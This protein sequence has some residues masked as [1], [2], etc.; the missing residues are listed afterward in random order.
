M[1]WHFS[2]ALVE[3][4]LGENSLDGEPSA[5]SSGT[6]THGMCWSLDKTTDA[7]TRSRSGMM[8]KPLTDT[9]GEAVLMS[10]LEAFPARTSVPQEK[11]RGSTESGAVCGATWQESS[12]KFDPD[13]SSWK[14]HLCLWEEDLPES[15]VTLPKWGMMRDGVCWE[16]TTLAL[17]IRGTESGSWPSPRTSGIC[18]GSGSREMIQAKVLD[19][20]LSEE[21]AVM[22]LGVK[23]WPTPAARDGKG[24]N[25]REHCET[26]GTGRKHMDQLP[27]AV[28]FPDLRNPAQESKMWPT[29]R[30]FMH[31][32]AG[33]DR[34]KANLGEVVAGKEGATKDRPITGQLNPNWVEWLM[35]WPIGWTDCAAS[36]TDKCQQWPHSPGKH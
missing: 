8:Y 1:S 24:S 30:C 6:D 2:Q 35:G 23:L 20:D 19:G 14:T 9:R 31:K 3:A 13:S 7:S 15:S 17:P 33:Y 22:M 34:G 16:R 18:G 32:D 27:N 11:E 26:N 10:F 25:S 12:V 5:P 28:A 29:P 36:G 4:S 21:T